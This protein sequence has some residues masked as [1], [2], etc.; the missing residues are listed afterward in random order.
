MPF[1]I[2]QLPLFIHIGKG[3]IHTL[4]DGDAMVKAHDRRG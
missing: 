1:F 3:K 4:N 2:I